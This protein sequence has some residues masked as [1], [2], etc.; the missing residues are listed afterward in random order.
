MSFIRGA[1]MAKGFPKNGEMSGDVPSRH[2]REG[3]IE[4]KT[5][6][7]VTLYGKPY[8]DM[9]EWYRPCS[10]CGVNFSVFEKRDAL[11][12]SSR[13]SYRTCDNHRNLMPAMEK[14]FITWSTELGGM[15][16]GA[17]CVSGYVRPMN[18]TEMDQLRMVNKTMKEELDC[19]YPRVKELEAKLAKYE[20]QSAMEALTKKLPWE[21]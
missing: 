16:P 13:F 12:A 10:V 2:S 18:N 7:S 19:L 8:R 11:D 9:K 14:G 21:R 4:G 1:K 15:V 20:L 3:W 17:M 5:H 6:N